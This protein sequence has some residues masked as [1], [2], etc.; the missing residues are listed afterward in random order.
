MAQKLRKPKE[1]EA[2][3]ISPDMVAWKKEFE[4]MKEED[5]LKK[6]AELGLSDEEL[7]EFKEMEHG[8]PIEDEI[9]TEGP[10]KEEKNPKT[11]KKT[12]KKGKK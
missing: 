1:G 12:I 3:P 4:E 7:E 2:L 10:L 9:L 8:V 5:H 11:V 6:L